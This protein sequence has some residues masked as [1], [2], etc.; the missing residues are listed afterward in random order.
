MKPNG[1]QRGQGCMLGIAG[2]LLGIGLTAVSALYQRQYY[3]VCHGGPG[4]GFPIVFVCDTS[5][6]SG[7][8][9]SSWGRIDLADWVNVNPLAFLMDLM[10]YST[11]LSLMWLVVTGLSTGGWTRDESF[12]WGILL[13]VGYLTVF[14][15]AFMAFQ[16]NSLNIEGASPRTPMPVIFS[17]TP[18]GTPP[19]PEF[20]PVPTKQS[21]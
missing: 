10:L 8:P 21:G 11:L 15:F 9:E 17:P 7:T 6:S 18:F 4:A 14:L 5:G 20:T 19:P 1:A 2:I 16:T 3:P 12:R 13:C